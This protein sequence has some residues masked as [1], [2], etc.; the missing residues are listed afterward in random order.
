MNRNDLDTLTGY[1][2][3]VIALHSLREQIAFFARH[4]IPMPMLSEKAEQLKQLI[5][6]FDDV[7]DTILDRRARHVISCRFALGMN[8]RE[9]ADY[10]R[11]S[12]M[13]VHRICK[14]ILSSQDSAGGHDP[15]NV[16]T[17]T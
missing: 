9:T 7:L 15:E 6:R 14:A 12:R 3:N 8:E 16:Q 5:L 11:L 10:L 4:G 2:E 17:S 13:T 1:R